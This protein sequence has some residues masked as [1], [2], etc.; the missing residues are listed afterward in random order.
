MSALAAVPV[1]VHL[2]TKQMFPTVWRAGRMTRPRQ[3]R[4]RSTLCDAPNSSVLGSLLDNDSDL[5][6][7]SPVETSHTFIA[8]ALPPIRFSLPADFSDLWNSVGGEP[9]SKGE[10][11]MATVPENKEATVPSPPLTASSDGVSISSG[12]S[13]VVASQTDSP[14]VNTAVI[15]DAPKPSEESR[16]DALRPPRLKPRSSRRS[17][18]ELA[19]PS[20]APSS[21]N[22]PSTSSSV[23]AQSVDRAASSDANRVFSPAIT[24]TQ[25][26]DPDMVVKRIQE[27]LADTQKRGV[28]QVKLDRQFLE[29]ILSALESKWNENTEMKSHIDGMKR[30]SRQYIE[31]LTVAQTEYDQELKARRDAESEV[32]RLRVLLSG[33]AARLTALSEESRRQELRQQRTKELNDDLTGLEQ[34]LSKL[35][36]ERDMTLAEVEELSLSKSSSNHETPPSN[37]SRSLTLRLDT[38]KSKYQ[39]ELIPL[40][41]QKESLAREIAELKA[42]RDVFLEE[43]TVL[44]ARNEELARLSTHYSRRMD[45]LPET[46]PKQPTP[47]IVT[48]NPP[49][50]SSMDRPRPPPPMAPAISLPA[51]ST[52]MHDDDSRF[53]SVSKTDVDIPTPG[54]KGFKW[55][56]VKTPLVNGSSRNKARSEHAFQQISNVRFTRCDHCGDK[57]WGSQ[58]R[59]SACALSVHVRCHSLVTTSCPQ[60]SARHKDDTPE[61]PSVSMFGRDLIEQVRADAKGGDLQVPIIVAKCITAVETLALD[62]EGIYRKTGGSS[63]TKVITQ[64]FE[65][66]DYDAFD[67]TDP[68]RFNDICSVTSVLK[69]YFRSLP[70]PLLTY[71]LHDRLMSAIQLRDASVKSATLIDLIGQLPSEHY[72]TVRFLMLHLH[73]VS[74][75]SA[76][77]LMNARNLGVVFGPTLL[78]SQDPGAEFSDMGSKALFIDWLIDNAPLVFSTDP[79][80]IGRRSVDSYS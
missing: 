43:T 31:G 41:E 27:V 56:I 73:N 53:I 60:Q 49:R 66:G 57:M 42:V 16:N 11:Q 80:H 12:V 37:M 64:L 3:L 40:K 65:S 68:E 15:N 52:S 74:Q 18:D 46:P 13:T 78:R 26:G 32:T 69:T 76:N 72:H 29:V 7:A 1:L 75:H 14:K 62:Y 38:I 23:L 63:H 6:D 2:D 36:V 17:T 33:Q 61:P 24:V 8:P 25:P 45:V 50:G 35:R 10:K 28:Q 20:T 39:R 58:L 30:E 55:P 51:P 22:S 47:A 54:K 4:K 77:N 67:L 70:N 48:P 44:N 5:S 34:N 71:E 79:P 19:R 59:C 21:S 9:P